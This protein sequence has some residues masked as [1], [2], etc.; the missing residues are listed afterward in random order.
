MI[1]LYTDK[2]TFHDGSMYRGHMVL[3]G[4]VESGIK[5]STSQSPASFPL[6]LQDAGVAGMQ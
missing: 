2:H 1:L 6:L 3:C 5:G 4:E